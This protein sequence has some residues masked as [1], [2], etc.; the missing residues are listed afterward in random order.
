MPKAIVSSVSLSGVHEFS[1]TPT[2]SITLLG[3]LGVRD[4]AHHGTKVQ[5]LSRIA[6]NPDQPN[7][8]QVHLLHEELLEELASQGYDIKPGNIGENIT[9]RGVDLLGLPTGARLQLGDQAVVEITGLRNPCHQIEKYQKG[10]LGKV[11]VKD[12]TTGRLV[13]KAGIMGVVLHGGDVKPG[14]AVEIRLP[15]EPHRPLEPV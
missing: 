13:R 12:A 1:K 15:K 9:T 5:H 10:L 8:R 2:S 4:D 14:D 7:L 3:G 11:L 6:K